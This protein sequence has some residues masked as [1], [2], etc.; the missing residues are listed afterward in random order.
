MDAHVLF[1]KYTE[2]TRLH[3]GW[4]VSFYV[5]PG[6][7]F[8][9]G[10]NGEWLLANMRHMRISPSSLQSIVISHDHWDHTGG[11]WKLLEVNPDVTVYGC[12]GFG[13]R[14]RDH[15]QR[16]GA[17]YM[18]CSNAEHIAQGIYS[19]GEIIGSYKNATIAEQGLVI[20]HTHGISI[21]TGCAHPGI[22]TMVQRIMERFDETQISLVMG[23]FHL[24]QTPRARIDDIV[25]EY[26]RLGVQKAGPTHC[27]G[28][29]AQQVFAQ[30]YQERF[31]QVAVG[32]SV[33]VD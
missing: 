24:M 13:D 19:S 3:T 8:D 16:Y 32:R 25:K 5:E 21:I 10:E 17:R 1:D 15:V 27:T 7:L 14:F 9:T 29:E 26:A 20:R 31:V 12:P 28:D 18:E 2:D 30:R 4:G 23:G 33:T 6:V 11:L 22:I